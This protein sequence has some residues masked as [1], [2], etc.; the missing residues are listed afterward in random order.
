MFTMHHV[1]QSANFWL[2]GSLY[3]CHSMHFSML[4]NKNQ[5]SIKTCW[6]IFLNGCCKFDPVLA[7]TAMLSFIWSPSTICE[8]VRNIHSTLITSRNHFRSWLCGGEVSKISLTSKR[9]NKV[10][11][12]LYSLRL[13]LRFLFHQ[14]KSKTA[15]TRW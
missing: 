13:L 11:I 3:Y 2:K 1:K 5:P 7:I 4:W 9:I 14:N 15:I 10:V 8:Y 12:R 6:D